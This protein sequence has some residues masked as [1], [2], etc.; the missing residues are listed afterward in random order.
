[1]PL[2]K[3]ETHEEVFIENGN[4]YILNGLKKED[5]AHNRRVE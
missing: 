4:G 3:Y 5:M 1:M 2:N